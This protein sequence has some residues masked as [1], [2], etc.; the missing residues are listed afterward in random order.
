MHKIRTLSQQSISLFV[1]LYLGLLLNLPIFIRRY[2][3]LH[4]DNA[5]S[6]AVEMVACFALVYFLCM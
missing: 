6:I 3:Q 2:Q 5:L 4:Y 1:A